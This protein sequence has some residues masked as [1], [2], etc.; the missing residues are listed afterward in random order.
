MTKP[1]PVNARAAW[2]LS[3]IGGAIAVLAILTAGVYGLVALA[4]VL[5]FAARL[6]QR[7]LAFGGVLVGA[8]GCLLITTQTLV[9]GAV[10]L[11]IG[12]LL[13][14][15]SLRRGVEGAKPLR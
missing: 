11:A 15:F 14:L 13:T 9:V 10:A 5:A 12:G 6:P 7:W 3:A 8:G 1:R 2:F 4:I